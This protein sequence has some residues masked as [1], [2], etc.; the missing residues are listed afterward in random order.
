MAILIPVGSALEQQQS[1]ER[2]VTGGDPASLAQMHL[3]LLWTYGTLAL[4][5]PFTLHSRDQYDQLQYYQLQ[6]YQLLA[7]Q[8]LSVVNRRAWQHGG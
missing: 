4:T 7:C 8:S 1:C 5:T 2:K 6:Y 3:A